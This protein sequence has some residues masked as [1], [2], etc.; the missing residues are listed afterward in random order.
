MFLLN[1]VH[2]DQ[3]VVFETRWCLSYL[4]GPLTRGQ[5]Q[6]LMA[7]RKGAGA[8]AAVPAPAATTTMSAG[9]APAPPPLPA[10]GN[11]N[12]GEQPLVP[13][14]VPQLYFK[15]TGRITDADVRL[16]FR[17]N[18]W[19]VARLHFVDAKANVDCWRDVT[20][21]VGIGSEVPDDPWIDSR[22]PTEGSL[23]PLAG[24][25]AGSIFLPMPAAPARPKS[26]ASWS[27]LLAGHLFRNQMLPLFAAPTLGEYSRPGESEGEFR[28]RMT[29]KNRETRDEALE[30]HRAKFAARVTAAE[31]QIQRAADRVARE[32]SEFN[33]QAT[34]TAVSFGQTVLRA[35]FGRKLASS[36]NV[37]SAAST[38]RSATRAARQREDIGRA[39]QQKEA[40]QVKLHEL[41]ADLADEQ[42]KIAAEF[43]SFVVEPYPIRPRK[44]DIAVEKVAL[45]WVD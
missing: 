41:E 12:S 34:Q 37:T 2:E 36:T 3:P 44:S 38:A 15:G 21:F 45:A 9:G 39:E 13:N 35:I 19:G 18:L 28:V 16:I 29:Q 5:I 42:A 11:I 32:K 6:T 20:V 7:D 4:R 40:A 10:T 17:P 31:N 30:K 25:P 24:P 22:Q 27:K 8:A 23:V 26:Y 14:E 1:N 33:A 43:E